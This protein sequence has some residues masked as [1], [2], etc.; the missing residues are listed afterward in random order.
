MSLLSTLLTGFTI[1]V[2]FLGLGMTVWLGLY[3]VALTPSR[4]NSWVAALLIWGVSLVFALHLL[5]LGQPLFLGRPW[6]PYEVLRWVA[7]PLPLIWFWLL[8]DLL[9]RPLRSRT[10]HFPRIAVG[11][12]LLLCVTT[13]L[14]GPGFGFGGIAEGRWR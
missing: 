3:L 9:P 11:I 10:R 6:L 14:L 13:A 1:L 2:G 4:V 5:Q 12:T 7:I 8:Y